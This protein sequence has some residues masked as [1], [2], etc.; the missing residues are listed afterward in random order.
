MASITPSTPLLKIV[1]SI[2]TG[3]TIPLKKD[4]KA[5]LKAN[6][7]KQSM[8][9]EA[10]AVAQ[11]LAKRRETARVDRLLRALAKRGEVSESLKDKAVR[12]VLV[13]MAG[14]SRNHADLPARLDSF[15]KAAIGDA[16]HR[17]NYRFA[18][19]GKV[20]YRLTQDPEEVGVVQVEFS[21]YETYRGKFKGWA[22]RVQN[23]TFIVPQNW[24]GRVERAGLACVDGMVTLDA[25]KLAASGC[26]LFAATWVEQG[27][28]TS[29]RAVKGYIARIGDVAC[30]AETADAAMAGV[31]K[32]RRIL[33]AELALDGGDDEL[34]RIAAYYGDMRVTVGDARAVGACEYGIRSWCYATGLPYEKGEA[35]L[36]DVLAAYRQ[37]PRIEAR[38][39]LL[40]VMR[41][42]RIGIARAA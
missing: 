9:D 37:Q 12:A 14:V 6:G 24:R 38:A 28:G 10:V 16:V 7:H 36:R 41:R 30:H 35:Q 33:A 34:S 31:A 20:S 19:N 32:K 5:A 23:T 2:M 27:R 13:S 26:D 25:A 11:L 8:V 29:L 18:V 21:D 40:R 17:C 4:L 42:A 22:A 39:T 1:A 15:R 3:L